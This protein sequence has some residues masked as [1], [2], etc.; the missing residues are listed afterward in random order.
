M[1]RAPTIVAAA[2][3]LALQKSPESCLQDVASQHPTDVSPGLW[4]EVKCV[5][6]KKGL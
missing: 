5:L 6:E 2:L 3:A 1:S 4:E